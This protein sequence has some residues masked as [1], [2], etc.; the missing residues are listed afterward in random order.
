MF[1]CSSAEVASDR[2]PGSM[3]LVIRSFLLLMI[4]RNRPP[5]KERLLENG[6]SYSPAI[7]GD[8]STQTRSRRNDTAPCGGCR[9]AGGHTEASGDRGAG[10]GP[11][12]AGD[13]EDARDRAKERI[14]RVHR[15]HSLLAATRPQA[16]PLPRTDSAGKICWASNGD[17]EAPS[18]STIM[19]EKPVPPGND[20]AG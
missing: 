14:K 5:R 20:G 3:I 17:A 4:M 19:S 6:S 7:A 8:G 11:T 15:E 2:L 13:S 10:T 12:T 1:A 16:K 18:C 9:H